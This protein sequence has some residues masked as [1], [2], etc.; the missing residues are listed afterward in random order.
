MLFS[1]SAAKDE[2]L[3]CISCNG[4]YFERTTERL[5]AFSSAISLQ[6]NNATR[7]LEFPLS[8]NRPAV[9]ATHHK[10]VQSE[11]QMCLHLDHLHFPVAFHLKKVH[12]QGVT[13]D[14]LN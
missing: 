9:C 2:E 5:F 7:S 1:F 14:R 13:F 6:A 11:E 3:T 4:E 10:M 12:Y 8:V